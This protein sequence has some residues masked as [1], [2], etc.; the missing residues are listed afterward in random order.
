MIRI[1]KDCGKYFSWNT[2]VEYGV[3]A[4]Y[5]TKSIGNIDTLLTTDNNTVNCDNFYKLFGKK[6]TAVIHAQQTHSDHIINID[7]NSKKCFFQ[8]TDAFITKRQD[9][10]LVTRYADCLPIFIYDNVNQ[11]I[12]IVHSGWQG[13]VKEIGPKCISMMRS[14]YNSQNENITVALGIGISGN[15]YEVGDEFMTMFYEK[16][17]NEKKNIFERSFFK[18]SDGKWHFDNAM[19]NKLNLINYGIQEQNIATSDLCT[20]SN[21]RFFSF[22]RD[23]TSQRNA[24][25]IFFN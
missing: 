19:F 3:N 6:V 8:D 13:T 4:I 23:H 24:G 11:I 1:L 7:Y 20:Y 12:S 2:F 15:C 18:T 21:S 5:T 9:I 22:R 17:S 16:F 14:L 10:A 25:I